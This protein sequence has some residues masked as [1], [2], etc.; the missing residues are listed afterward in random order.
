MIVVNVALI[1]V[2][3]SAWEWDQAAGVTYMM[4]RISLVSYL[5][6]WII[7]AFGRELKLLRG[8]CCWISF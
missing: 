4:R 2:V 7:R 5:A 1:C 8:G 3:E 6:E